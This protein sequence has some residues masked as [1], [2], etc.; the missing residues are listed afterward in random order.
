MS[1]KADGAVFRES[2]CADTPSIPNKYIYDLLGSKLFDA[3]CYTPENYLTRT[4]A[5]IFDRHSEEAAGTDTTLI[6]HGAGNCAKAARLIPYIRPHQYVPID[7]S[8]EFLEE[9]VGNLRS[10]FPALESKK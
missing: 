10:A 5:A 1:S 4:E 7:I 3:I 2:L 6:E 8:T 9:G